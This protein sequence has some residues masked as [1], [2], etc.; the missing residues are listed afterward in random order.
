MDGLAKTDDHG[1]RVNDTVII[2]NAAGVHKCLVVTAAA[3]TATI[4]VA[5]YGS[6]AIADSTGSLS[7]TILVYGSEYGKGTSYMTGG[8]TTTQQESRGAN[9]PSFKTFSNKPIIMKLS[10]IHI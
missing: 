6:A 8:A 9:E 4:D 1:I 2:A 3:G 5:P 10:L 7:C